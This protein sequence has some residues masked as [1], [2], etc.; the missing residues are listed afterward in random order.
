VPASRALP[1][2][3]RPLFPEVPIETAV[4]TSSI[5][6]L[7]ESFALDR[8]ADESEERWLAHALSQLLQLTGATAAFF[9]RPANDGW[10]EL[11]LAAGAIGL[12]RIRHH[13][14]WP[15]LPRAAADAG[16]DAQGGRG[17]PDPVLVMPVELPGGSGTLGLEGARAPLAPALVAASAGALAAASAVRVRIAELEAEVVTDELTE[18]HNYRFLRR[19]LDLEVQRAAR[20]GHPLAA[21]MVDV[22]HLKAYNDRFGHLAGSQVLKL[23]ARAL[24]SAT[25]EFDLVAKY[26]GDEFMLILPHTGLEDAAAAA[27][28]LRAAVA[29]TVFPPLRAGEM[30]CSIGIA[31]FPGDGRSPE[32]LLQAADQ[33]LFAAKRSGR[34]RAETARAQAAGPAPG[35]A[36]GSPD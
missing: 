6:R 30:T 34:N 29:G 21:L 23:V 7:I 25:R 9:R 32:A 26:G 12:E 18:V 36:P 20:Y 28:R 35:P 19:A 24:R 33:A 2:A 8:G 10:D 17:E 5:Y 14:P 4:A 3:S 1:L 16:A 27:E 11:R 13:S 31:V 22:D 15:G